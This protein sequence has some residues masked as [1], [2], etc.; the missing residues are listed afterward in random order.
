MK[1]SVICPIEPKKTYPVGSEKS[2]VRPQN[3]AFLPSREKKSEI[4]QIPELRALNW[5]D[6]Q[7]GGLFL[8]M[9]K[10]LVLEIL[11]C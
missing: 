3:V 9:F 7:N 1:V 2:V 8:N 6:H 4:G 10:K 11:L 5:S